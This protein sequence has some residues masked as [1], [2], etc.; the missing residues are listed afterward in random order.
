MLR[1]L[2]VLVIA[3]CDF[4]DDS[5]LS[6]GKGRTGR[7]SEQEAP[8]PEP[9]TD[10]S[11]EAVF[12]RHAGEGVTREQLSQAIRV[13]ES[14]QNQP[15]VEIL[16]GFV[17][18]SYLLENPGIVWKLSEALNERYDDRIKLALQYAEGETKRGLVHWVLN[19]LE[20]EDYDVALRA[21]EACGPGK[22][23]TELAQ[24]TAGMMASGADRATLMEWLSNLDFPEERKQAIE[25]AARTLRGS[26]LTDSER[27]WLIQF[28]DEAG[29]GRPVRRYL[30]WE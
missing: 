20:H 28:A 17:E 25:S 14:Q 7:Q 19:D 6:D 27:N 23:R 4:S 18:R 12:R 21:F 29:A 24:R 16:P 2:P 22:L 13:A 11:L 10:I 1:F 26:D 30:A 15:L 5:D 9:A 8:E 3:S